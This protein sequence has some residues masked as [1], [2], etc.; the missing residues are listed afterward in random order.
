ML[1]KIA[2]SIIT[3]VIAGWVLAAFRKNPYGR[4]ILLLNCAT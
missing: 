3:A 1:A 2:I 4:V